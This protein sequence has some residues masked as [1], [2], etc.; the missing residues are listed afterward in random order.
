VIDW[1]QLPSPR[2]LQQ[3]IKRLTP[4]DAKNIERQLEEMRA[5]FR[6]SQFKIVRAGRRPIK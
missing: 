3:I 4:E 6:R 2:K 1:S 5:R